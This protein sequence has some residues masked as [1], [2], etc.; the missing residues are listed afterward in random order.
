MDSDR[1]FQVI[2]DVVRR[3]HSF[4]L[5]KKRYRSDVG[6]FHF[7]DLIPVV[8]LNLKVSFV[9][10][11]MC[12]I[13]SGRIPRKPGSILADE[14]GWTEHLESVTILSRGF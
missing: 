8:R 1:F 7:A 14:T 9:S 12:A 2:G 3:G 4:K 6:E 11:G 5:F 13:E 10:G